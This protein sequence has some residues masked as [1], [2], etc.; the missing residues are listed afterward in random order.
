MSGHMVEMRARLKSGRRGRWTKFVRSFFLRLSL[1]WQFVIAATLVLGITMLVLGSWIS[2]RIADGVMRRSAEA[3][4]HYMEH[5]L[6]PYV[7]QLAD[8][9]KL[10][11]EMISKLD[12]VSANYA[13]RR[14]VV[15]IKVWRP[16]GTI[17][18]STEKNLIGRT[19]PTEEIEPALKGEVHGYLNRLDEDEN[20]FE[21]TLSVPLY[22]IYGPL[23]K[24]G[25]REVIA[26]GE[27]YENGEQLNNELVDAVTDNW[28]VVGAAGVGMLLVLFAIVYRGSATIDR[29]NAALKQRFRQQVRLHRRNEQLREKMQNALRETARI[30]HVTQRRLGAELHDGPAQLLTFV[31]LR[32]DEIEDALRGVSAT[33]SP[34]SSVVGQV[35]DA[36]TDALAD[37][38][39][40]STGLFLPS[41]EGGHVAEVVK[42]II[43]GHERRNGSTVSFRADDIPEITEPDVVQCLARV[44]QEALS[45][46][47]KHAGGTD[48]EVALSFVNSVLRLV[49]RDGGPGMPT[50][51]AL[52]RPSHQ[53]LGLAG[54][55][56]RVES[57]GGTVIFRSLPKK[58]FEVICEVPL[59]AF[60]KKEVN[61]RPISLS[62]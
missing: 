52:D 40:I 37:L 59:S 26:V 13:L 50:Y 11:S 36:A 27:F 33:P 62:T 46:A 9:E 18:Y 34:V 16:D 30:D 20:V 41:I 44:V 57:L 55:K 7:Q 35:R 1:F 31:L 47:Q 5:V 4:A 48:S 23:F 56:Y 15:S 2:G 17:A 45:N 61:E 24:T 38:R 3:A 29:Q 8:G 28:L 12:E 60:R 43:V 19:F 53:Q 49:I 42:A 14:H 21:R 22:E 6:E 51:D 32:L 58:G 39:S 54:I 25:T 10:S